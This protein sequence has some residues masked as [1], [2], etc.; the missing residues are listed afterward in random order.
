MNDK[1][2]VGSRP[3]RRSPLAPT[4]S[5][6]RQPH[7]WALL[8]F[9]GPPACRMT[10]APDAWPKAFA[11]RF[12]KCGARCRCVIRHPA[13][14]KPS[15]VQHLTRRWRVADHHG[16]TRMDLRKR[17]VCTCAHSLR[18]RVTPY[19]HVASRVLSTRGYCYGAKAHQFAPVLPATMQWR[20][21]G[22]CTESQVVHNFV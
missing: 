3:V 11:I 9:S 10:F 20:P 6:T 22:L 2:V 16:S 17:P 4:W 5:S 19:E 13:R 7:E 21:L 1:R 15:R 8:T 18:I 14:A 12:G